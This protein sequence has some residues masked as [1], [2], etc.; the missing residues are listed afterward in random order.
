[1]SWDSGLLMFFNRPWHAQMVSRLHNYINYDIITNYDGRTSS[2]IQSVLANSPGSAQV[3]HSCWESDPKDWTTVG[4]V[5]WMKKRPLNRIRSSPSSP[6]RCLRRRHQPTSKSS[7]S[8]SFVYIYINAL[9]SIF[10]PSQL[11]ILAMKHHLTI[12]T[13]SQTWWRK[14][15]DPAKFS[16]E[17]PWSFTMF[18]Q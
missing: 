15:P 7:P 2:S 17:K 18:Q 11:H 4:S 8:Q 14:E 13:P 12:H 1:M 16:L 10:N 9:C 3:F 6:F 5:G